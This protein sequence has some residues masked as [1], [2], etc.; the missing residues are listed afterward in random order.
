[1][2]WNNMYLLTSFKSHLLVLLQSNMICF[3]FKKLGNHLHKLST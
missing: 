2:I 1:M 3:F